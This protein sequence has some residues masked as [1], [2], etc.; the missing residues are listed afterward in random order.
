VVYYLS[1]EARRPPA[2]ASGE[3]RDHHAARLRV[4]LGTLARSVTLR[5]KDEGTLAVRL[6]YEV[7]GRDGDGP[8]QVALATVVWAAGRAGLHPMRAVVTRVGSHWTQGAIAGALTGVGLSQTQDDRLGPA[9]TLAAIALGAVGG[10]F[11][12]REVPV[13]RALSLPRAG[14]RLAAVEPEA[15]PPRFRLGLA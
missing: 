7:D 8:H 15:S 1:L 2:W 13:L 3:S 9:I 4:T 12:R 10:A 6:R 11:L 5:W 14:W